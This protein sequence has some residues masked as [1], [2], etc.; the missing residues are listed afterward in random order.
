HKHNNLVI[1]RDDKALYDAYAGYWTDLQAQ[2]QDLN[3]YRSFTGD[4]GTKAYFYPRASGDTILGVLD[5]VTCDSGTSIRVAMAFFTSG[6]SEV[7]ER[8]VSKR[9]QGCGVSV[10]LDG[11]ELSNPV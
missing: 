10:V 6:R 2:Q 5:N 4:T 9:Q 1:I 7:A 8:L 11:A 3:Y